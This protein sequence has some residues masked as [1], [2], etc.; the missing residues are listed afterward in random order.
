M[1]S[2]DSNPN[3]ERSRPSPD[4]GLWHS[5]LTRR[6][7]LAGAAVAG[8]GAGMGF[9]LDR[10][11]GTPT[12]A[13][14]VAVPFYGRH[15]AGIATPQ[16]S[17]LAF[18]SFDVTTSSRRALRALLR[19]W[20]EAA[21]DLTAGAQPAHD[22]GEAVG[23]PPS[24]L[25]LT[26]GFGPTLFERDGHDRFGLARRR[27][28]PLAPLPPFPGDQLDAARS[29]GDLCVQACA[30]D[31]QVAFHAIHVLT[32]LAGEDAVLRW[33]QE[34]FRRA[35]QP[36]RPTARNLLGF[37]DGTANIRTSDG[38]AMDRFVWT[39]APDGPAWLHGGTYLVARRIEIVLESWD[40]LTVRQ[41]EQAIGRRKQSGAPLGGRHEHDPLDLR[42]TD[43]HGAPLVPADAHVRVASSTANEGRQILRRG[44]SYTRGARPGPSDGGGHQLD[45]GLFFI[46][47]T[48]DPARQFVPLQR[49]LATHDALSMFT[50]H[51]ASAVFACPPGTQPGGFVGESLLA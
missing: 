46:A 30:D 51:T 49:R 19:R 24:R 23:L 50:V 16:Q 9:A 28:A 32:R 48:R 44:Y 36:D 29:G 10:T 1:S 39:R 6:S 14:T 43:E 40:S 22:P 18:A 31:P 45:A 4:R 2:P 15:Q 27:P 34:G 5:R 11:V 42:A 17:E 33:M 7:L 3:A 21:A 37:K 13:Q 41:Q 8:A 35:M 12:S 20:T 47:F 25:T 26:F 38:A